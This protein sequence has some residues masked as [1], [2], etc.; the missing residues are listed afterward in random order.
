MTQ[1]SSTTRLKEKKNK[2]QNKKNTTT[3]THRGRRVVDSWPA[4]R[5][6]ATAVL[7]LTAKKDSPL[8]DSTT[9]ASA[10]ASAVSSGEALTVALPVGRVCCGRTIMLD[11]LA[12]K[13]CRWVA[14]QCCCFD[15][16]SIISCLAR[17]PGFSET[18][19]NV[20]TVV[21]TTTC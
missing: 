5:P 7:P 18:L 4:R 8:K 14:I 13:T 11:A 20:S 12:A 10:A 16:C 1:K 21:V 17:P 15:V 3:K 9:A 2:N 6:A 19:H